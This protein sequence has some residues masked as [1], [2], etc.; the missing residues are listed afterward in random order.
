MSSVECRVSSVECRVINESILLFFSHYSTLFH[1]WLSFFWM[2]DNGS[3]GYAVVLIPRRTGH[4]R[5]TGVLVFCFLFRCVMGLSYYGCMCVC[6]YERSG[7]RGC[8]F[9]FGVLSAGEMR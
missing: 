4:S 5:V 7:F 6:K 1:S 3:L 2:R 8:C 9:F